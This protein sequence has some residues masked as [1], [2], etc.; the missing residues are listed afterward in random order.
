M[1]GLVKAQE[2]Q[3]IGN[4]LDKTYIPK[5][6]S[7]AGKATHSRSRSSSR[8]EPVALVRIILRNTTRRT[9]ILPV[10][11]LQSKQWTE[12]PEAIKALVAFPDYCK[13]EVLSSN[14]WS[15]RLTEA[16]LKKRAGA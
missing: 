14:R 12:T 4:L 15:R 8:W 10:A 6:R 11:N 2:A 16:S 7:E 5:Q 9:S 13:V 3:T 1:A